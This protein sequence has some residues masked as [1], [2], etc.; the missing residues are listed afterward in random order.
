MTVLE[1]VDYGWWYAARVPGERAAALVATDPVTVRGRA[2]NSPD[3]W[4]A[5][6]RGTTHLAGVLDGATLDPA[7]VHVYAAPSTRLEP[8]AGKRWVAVGDAAGAF[9]PLSSQGIHKALVDGLDAGRAVAEWLGGSPEALVGYR[10]GVEARFAE[11]LRNRAFLYGLEQRW[12][13]QPFWRARHAEA[14]TEEGTMP[15]KATTR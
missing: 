2:L 11:Y 12:A 1:A 4:S 9:D 15:A 7:G 3:G 8:C 13:D 5:A 6:L 14:G 10:A